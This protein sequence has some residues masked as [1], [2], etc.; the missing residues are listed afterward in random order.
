MKGGSLPRVAHPG[1]FSR[2]DLKELPAAV[3]VATNGTNGH[4]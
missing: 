1:G 2:E 3:W 4:E